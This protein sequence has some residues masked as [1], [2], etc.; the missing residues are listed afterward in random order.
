MKSKLSKEKIIKMNV[1]ISIILISILLIFIL[2]KNNMFQIVRNRIINTKQEE[3]T[4]KTE[5]QIM[6]VNEQN[7]ET[8]ITIE[9]MNGIERITAEDITIEGKGKKKIALDRILE[10][11]K[12][13][14]ISVKLV[15]EETEE[16]YTIVAERVPT[17]SILNIDALGDG[18]TK[19]IKID[20]INNIEDN[21]NYYSLD[22]GATW[23]EYTGEL[24]ILEADNRTITA[25]SDVK[26]E[27][28]KGKLIRVQP[29]EEFLSLVI[30]RSLL[31]ATE[32]AIMKNDTY[33]RMAIK[34][35]EYRVHT[36]IENEDLILGQN[37]VYGNA[38]DAG[39][40]SRNA[41]SMVILKVNGNMTIN[42]GVTVTSYGTAYGGTKGMLLYVTG[43]LENNGAITMTARGAKAVG[44]NV[45]LWKN[46]DASARGE[47]EFVPKVGA[48]GGASVNSTVGRAGG[49][50]TDRRT[51]GGGSGASAKPGYNPGTS[52]RGG[53]GTSYSGG[54]GGGAARNSTGQQGNDNG[55]AGGNAARPSN[56]GSGSGGGAGNP[57]GI[58]STGQITASPGAN[59]TGGLLILYGNTI[60]N[61]GTIVSNGMNGGQ[62]E[63]AGGGASGGGSINIFFKESITKGTIS[64]TGGTGGLSY[65]SFWGIE[66]NKGG[67]GGNGSVS[68]G[69]I[70]TG[71]YVSN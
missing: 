57:G 43:N 42:S 17:I 14:P 29:Q 56:Y 25:K 39:T 65:S 30:S 16:E 62:G 23:Q 64:A 13:Y 46:E 24:N 60:D 40:S 58:N 22:D 44:Q 3:I 68:T 18:S 31:E 48:G 28:I 41:T 21:N 53:N 27:K 52:G 61:K 54:P 32:K 71:T 33:Y 66:G 5:C 55:G 59:G 26:Q 7:M 4:T 8:I 67:A 38:D 15:G 19:T 47:Y 37:K 69:S 10:N 11:G 20:Y 70:A 36:Y 1:I 34:D 35:E 6:K 9:N 50:G 2:Y 51:G 12:V 49:A 63:A 45:Y